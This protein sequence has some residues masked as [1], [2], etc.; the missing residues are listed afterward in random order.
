MD[1]LGALAGPERDASLAFLTQSCGKAAEFSKAHSHFK[2]V[3][4][5]MM[6]PATAMMIA[7]AVTSVLIPVVRSVLAR[8]AEP[9]ETPFE[10]QADETIPTVVDRHGPR[11]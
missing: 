4:Q 9:E 6:W 7:A 5:W 1:R 10:S 3:V 8:K 11:R 2:Y